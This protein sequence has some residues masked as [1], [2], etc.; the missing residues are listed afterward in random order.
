MDWCFVGS[1]WRARTQI[2]ESI[3]TVELSVTRSSAIKIAA[4]VAKSAYAD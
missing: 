2:G 3:E 1:Y 4:D